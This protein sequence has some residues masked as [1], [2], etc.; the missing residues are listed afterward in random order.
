MPNL[1]YTLVKQPTWLH[2]C[3]QFV[4]VEPKR[5]NP[6]HPHANWSGQSEKAY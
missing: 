5:S 1:V 3:L 6:S 4:L 2:V